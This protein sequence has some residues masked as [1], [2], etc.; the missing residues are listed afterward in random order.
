MLSAAL[1]LGLASPSPRPLVEW[2]VEGRGSFVMEFDLGEAPLI[3]RHVLDLVS[4]GFYDRQIIHRRVEN[5]V[6][7]AGDPASK[8]WTPAR[9]LAAPG[10]SGGTKGLG[11]GGSGKP[12]R[13]EIN[14]LVHA[15]G[16]VGMALESPMSDTGDSQWFINLKNNFRLNGMY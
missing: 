3:G 7:Q 6:L 15:R 11:D 8:G 12:V 4:R 9:A 16:T 2:Q 5:F 10:E 13:F 1:A 14:N